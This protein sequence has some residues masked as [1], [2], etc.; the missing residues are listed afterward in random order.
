[1]STTTDGV[2]EH[3]GFGFGR[4]SRKTRRENAKVGGGR[5]AKRSIRRLARAQATAA[6][7]TTTAAAA[8]AAVARRTST[9]RWWFVDG[10][11]RRGS[12]STRF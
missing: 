6:D 12:T 9:R 5:R 1:M 11:L 7:T 2:M 3:I 10:E 4:P 8:A